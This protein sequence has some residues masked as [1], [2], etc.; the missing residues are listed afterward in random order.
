MDL[1]SSDLLITDVTAGPDKRRFPVFHPSPHLGPLPLCLQAHL[2]HKI[3]KTMKGDVSTN[4]GMSM[5][6]KASEKCELL[7]PTRAY[8][9]K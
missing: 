3:S 1:G 5:N 6:T 9:R 2:W 7:G 8:Q 4:Q